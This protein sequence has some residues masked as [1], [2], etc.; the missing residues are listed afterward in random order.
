M[1]GRYQLTAMPAEVA[2]AFGVAENLSPARPDIRP[3]QAV[4]VIRPMRA[5]RALVPM[6]WGFVPDW[7][8]SPDD[9]PLIINARSETLAEKPAFREA[10]RTRRC[11]I[12]ANGFYEWQT[13]RGG[14]RVHH[15]AAQNE[16]VFAFAGIWQTGRSTDGG[17]VD[18]VAIVTCAAP[19]PLSH[20][21][22]RT[23]IVI[24]PDHYPLW[25]GEAGHGA[26]RLMQAAGDGFWQVTADR[27]PPDTKPRLI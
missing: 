19:E 6:R 27:G 15:L 5:G 14:K 23:P 9:G 20:I 2:S 11:L 22:A 17:Q 21:H 26:A 3:T 10:C 13:L 1:C 16:A 12:P 7:Y 24:Q 8:R 25:L 18:T 4:D